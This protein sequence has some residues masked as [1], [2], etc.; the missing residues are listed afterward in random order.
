MHMEEINGFYDDDG[1]T[2]NP[3]LL[4][5]PQLCLLCKGNKDDDWEENL[6]CQMNRWD[7]RNS[8]DF[9]CGAYETQS[10]R[11]LKSHPD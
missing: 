10:G 7:Q 8:L 6:L 5:K 9:K 11:D 1:N 2:I 3:N 4:S